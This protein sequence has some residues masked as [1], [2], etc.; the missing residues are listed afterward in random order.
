MGSRAVAFGREA[1]YP[2]RMSKRW[3]RPPL[4]SLA[5]LIAGAAPSFG[6]QASPPS[7]TPQRPSL[8]FNA[9]TVPQGRF[10]IEAGA[11]EADDGAA[12][13]LFLKY[14]L[15]E[16]LEL[17]LGADVV[18]TSRAGG[19]S[20]TSQ[21]DLT[22]GLRGREERI[23]GEEMGGAAL[24]GVAWVKVPTADNEVG[25]GNLDAGAIGIL[26]TPIEDYSL[27]LNLGLTELGRGGGSFLTQVQA[28][29]TLGFPAA[30][31]WL[32]FL[33]TAWQRTAGSGSGGALSFGT[34]YQPLPSLVIDAAAGAGY[35]EG[36]PDWWLTVGWTVL[37]GGQDARPSASATIPSHRSFGQ[38][39][40]P[41]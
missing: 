36:Y 41:F 25:S 5:L 19:V 3:S 30:G 10:E 9:W 21:G 38:P 8:S 17:E 4:L 37:L 26:S 20:E 33:E 13:P 32:P 16:R 31:R 22:L 2:W 12:V 1:G 11:L 24:G 39:S 18:R 15:A 6:Q 27:D 7:A 23:G 35:N 28:I 40:S 34:G 14:G 29:A